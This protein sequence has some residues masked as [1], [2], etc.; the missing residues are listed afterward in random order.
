MEYSFTN[1]LWFF[2]IY[3]F[4]GWWIEVA[5]HALTKGNFVNRGFLNGPVCPIYGFGMIALLYFFEPFAN[6]LVFLFVG[7]IFFT[8]TL[9]FVTGF[10]LEKVFHDKWWDYSDKPFNLKGY[11]CLSF[12]IM[13]GLGA[14]FMIHIVQPSIAKFISIFDNKIGNYLLILLLS[15]FIADFI[16]TILGILKIN[17]RFHLLEEMSER[18]RLY[19]DEIG[20]GIYKRVT[21]TMKAKESIQNKIQDSKAEFEA[22]MEKDLDIPALKEKYDKLLKEKHFVHKRLEKAYPK[23]K[24]KLSKLE[25][26]N[27]SK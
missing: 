2:I 27:Q 1:Y 20:E 22:S 10:I 26:P 12:S 18:L 23:V 13:W 4:L 24:E 11:V 7:S 8:S 16:V 25:N 9:E 15:Y 6:N 3:A 5:Y 14:V 19:S 21:T 17:K